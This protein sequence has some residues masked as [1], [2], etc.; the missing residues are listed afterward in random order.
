MV[1]VNQKVVVIDV[2]HGG[3][4]VGVVG[5]LGTKESELNLIIAQKLKEKFE[6]AGLFVV[7]TRENN[8]G[9]YESDAKNK[10]DSE[11]KK[12]K[13]IIQNNDPDFVI[14]IHANQ[15][16]SDSTR[17]GAQVFYDEFNKEG[18]VLSEKIQDN[19]NVLNKEKTGRVCENLSGDF[20]VLK[21]T[22]KPSVLIECGFLSNEDDEKLLIDSKYQDQLTFAIY[23]GLIAFLEE[24]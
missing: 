23:S 9:L 11:M 3:R 24:K 22:T 2:G 19:L 8:E 17:R 13:E 15:F 5:S 20:F 18:K 14:S 4:D 1:P 10:K 21:C 16:P 7:L 6:K 12:R